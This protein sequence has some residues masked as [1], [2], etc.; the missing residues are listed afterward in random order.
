[1]TQQAISQVAPALRLDIEAELANVRAAEEA[2][3]QSWE[4][5]CGYQY[6]LRCGKQQWWD[7]DCP[8]RDEPLDVVP[9]VNY[10]YEIQ[11]EDWDDCGRDEAESDVGYV[12][13]PKCKTT[14]SYLFWVGDDDWNTAD[15][16]NRALLHHECGLSCFD[17]GDVLYQ[18]LKLQQSDD[19]DDVVCGDCGEWLGEA[20]GSSVG[21]RTEQ[22]LS[23][24]R[25]HVP[26][27][28]HPWGAGLE[29]LDDESGYWEP[30]PDKFEEAALNYASKNGHPDWVA[31]FV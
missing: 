18:P 27:C 5:A 20:Q 17:D 25:E 29:D 23:L 28:P 24:Y 22:R 11:H 3:F 7:E 30:S 6:C 12:V 31:D 14:L 15:S 1:M 13:C 21:V 8:C 4:E 2:G 16:I 19:E 26:D 9:S 10:D